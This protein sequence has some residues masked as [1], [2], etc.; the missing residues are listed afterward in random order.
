M[1][2]FTEYN[3]EAGTKK[4]GEEVAQARVSAGH[5]DLHNF[6]RGRDANSYHT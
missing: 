6:Q 4:I 2:R 1:K 5:E 3:S